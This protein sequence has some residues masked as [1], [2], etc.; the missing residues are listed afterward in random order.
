MNPSCKWQTRVAALKSVAGF[1]DHAPEQLGY[2]LPLVIPKVSEC[3]VDLK[4]EVCD[5]AQGAMI[6]VCDVVGNRDIEHL[7]ANILRS[8]T[9]P[10]D[11]EE[12]MHKL[13]G[14]TFVQSVESPALAMVTPLL[15]RGLN[16]KKT[17]TLR[18]SA[19]II[20]NM[21]R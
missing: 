3:V 7:T 12:L 21:S 1:G 2:A 16:S 14:V 15:I 11:T 5:A 19:V 8:I 13:A 10:E 9:H 4:T 17:A 6:A 18:Q 20:D